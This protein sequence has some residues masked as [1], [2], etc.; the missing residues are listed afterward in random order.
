MGYEV[1]FGPDDVAN[2]R[3]A[4]SP[5]WETWQAVRVLRCAASG[6]SGASGASSGRGSVRAPWLRSLAA[7][8]QGLGLD[9]GAL[10]ALQPESGYVPDFISPLVGSPSPVLA[11][12]LEALRRTSV[13]TVRSEL[14]QC[15]AAQSDPRSRQHIVGLLNDPASARSLLADLV[16]GCWEELVAATWPDVRR[17]LEADVHYRAR[18]LADGG[19]A[20][21]LNAI[22][23]RVSFTHG[24][25]RIP[26]HRVGS[27]RLV[28]GGAVLRPSVFVWPNV[29]FVADQS[30]LVYPVRGVGLLG[31]SGSFGSSASASFSG[32]PGW[33]GWPVAEPLVRLLGRTRAAIL[34]ALTVPCST[35][36]LAARMG[37]R[38]GGVSAHL[39]VLRAAG[40]ATSRRQGR[41]VLYE[42]S[43]L[44]R[45]L[46]EPDSGRSA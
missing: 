9:L 2:C 15:L 6:A 35:S 26:A 45:T 21:V 22:D 14:R 24:T 8:A 40:L 17:L 20:E 19:L 32:S 37:L 41:E 1:S 44:G 25:L 33:P 18:R 4:V 3:F 10:A 42:C 12:E 43:A 7:R 31:S 39:A 13:A 27:C 34:S 5:I 16:E 30:V 46:Q 29:L 28:G 36:A 11:D 23:R 38:P